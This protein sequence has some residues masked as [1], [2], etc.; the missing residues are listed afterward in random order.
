M[1]EL[2]LSR[3]IELAQEAV[4]VRGEDYV[5]DNPKM[6]SGQPYGGPECSY[7]HFQEP[8]CIVGFIYWLHGASAET[9]RTA[10]EIGAINQVPDTVLPATSD[11]RDFLVDLQ[12]QQDTYQP[13][14]LAL[15]TAIEHAAYSR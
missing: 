1:E 15:R 6:K 11:A 8:G 12:S 10:D 9:L 7:W 3:A 13:W 5:Y 14:G 4:R 2:T